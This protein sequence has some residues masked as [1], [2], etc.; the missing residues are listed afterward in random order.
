M[1]AD[2]LVN[3][4]QETWHYLG[5]SHAKEPELASQELKEHMTIISLKSTGTNERIRCPQGRF[6]SPGTELRSRA[7]LFE[8]VF[9]REDCVPCQARHL[10]TVKGAKKMFQLP[11]RAQYMKRSKKQRRIH[12]S[13]EGKQLYNKRA[14]VE[15]T[16]SQ[17]CTGVW[18]TENAVSW[19][20]QNT[21]TA[22]CNGGGHQS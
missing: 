15:G 2:L 7:N 10:C 12:A 5:W 16:I 17:G 6:L 3:S 21:F 19:F 11:P 14:G 18:V 8:V 20:G 9:R 22:H 1:D 13:E 4:P